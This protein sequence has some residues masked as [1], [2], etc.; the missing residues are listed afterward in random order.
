MTV[1]EHLDK[2]DALAQGKPAEAR[3]EYRLALEGMADR[4]AERASAL[5]KQGRVLSRL[6]I[7]SEA[8]KVLEEA[9]EIREKEYGK[10]HLQTAEVLEV[11]GKTHELAENYEESEKALERS[12]EIRNAVCGVESPEVAET[13]NDL[14]SVLTAQNKLKEADQLLARSLG[15]RKRKQGLGH[16]DYAMS[17]KNLAVLRARQEKHSLAEPFLRQAL[18][19]SERRLGSEHAEVAEMYNVLGREYFVQGFY[20]RGEKNWKRSAQIWEKTLPEEHPYRITN[21]NN[22]GACAVGLRRTEE[23]ADLYE[24]A[25]ALGERADKDSL[26]VLDSVLGLGIAKLQMNKFNEAEPYIK[27]A[28]KMIDELGSQQ[29]KMEYPLIERLLTCYIFQLKVGDALRLVPDQMR[30]KHTR[31]FGST[32]DLLHAVAAYLRKALNEEEA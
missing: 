10:D 27:R 28:L 20:D 18:Q 13:L 6:A 16:P 4:N 9:L 24:R 1:K 32:M 23:G 31:Q 30:A 17:L 22:L 21:L 15:I 26:T 5:L 7:Y 19:I 3:E 11:L 2:A 12:L 29:H 25:L 8:I 14:G